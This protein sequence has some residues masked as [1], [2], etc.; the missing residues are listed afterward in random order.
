MPVEDVAL[1]PVRIANSAGAITQDAGD[2]DQLEQLCAAFSRIMTHAFGR[3]A[4]AP[5]PA[6]SGRRGVA[7]RNSGP[8]EGETTI[9]ASWMRA[10]SGIGGARLFLYDHLAARP[11]SRIAPQQL[12]NHEQQD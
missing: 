8:A 3:D 10:D 2:F 6:E 12:G 7:E 5:R 9:G 1:Q 11:A 4:A